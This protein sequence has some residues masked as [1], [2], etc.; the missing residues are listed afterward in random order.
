MGVAWTVVETV[1]ELHGLT[2]GGA[3]DEGWRR[4]MPAQL[5]PGQDFGWMGAASDNPHQLVARRVSA[6]GRQG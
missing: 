3:I 2:R 5:R 1:E 4:K 6:A